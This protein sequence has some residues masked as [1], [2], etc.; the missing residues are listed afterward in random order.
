M[1]NIDRQSASAEFCI[2]MMPARH[3]GDVTN[4]AATTR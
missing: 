1:S 3:G 4:N 2:R